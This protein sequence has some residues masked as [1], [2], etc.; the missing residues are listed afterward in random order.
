MLKLYIRSISLSPGPDG[1][2]FV[3]LRPS[4]GTP[5]EA[6]DFLYNAMKNRNPVY[7]ADPTQPPDNGVVID[8]EAY[9]LLLALEGDT[10]EDIPMAAPTASEEEATG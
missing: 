4:E 7:V 10:G 8:P 1:T 5:K 3:L 9:R 2:F 6:V